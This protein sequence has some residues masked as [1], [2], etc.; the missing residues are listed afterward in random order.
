MTAPELAESFRNGN[1]R[2]VADD[3]ICD[4]Q[5]ALELA[6][7]LEPSEVARLIKAVSVGGV[8]TSGEARG[9]PVRF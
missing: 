6:L 8:R 5:R 9:G 1:V 7:L 2:Q 3:V 4:G